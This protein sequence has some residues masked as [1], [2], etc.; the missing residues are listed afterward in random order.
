MGLP[1]CV[2]NA[3]SVG[4]TY[5]A[6]LGGVSYGPP[7]PCT[8]STTAVDKVTCFSDSNSTT[9]IFAP[10]AAIR[11]TGLGSG[12]VTYYGTSQASP[13]GAGCEP[14][15]QLRRGRHG[16]FPE[17]VARVEEPKNNPS[18]VK[19]PR[20][21]EPSTRVPEDGASSPGAAESHSEAD[22]RDASDEQSSE[23]SDRLD[24][25]AALPAGRRPRQRG[26]RRWRR[27]PAVRRLQRLQRHRLSR[28]AADL[29][30]HQ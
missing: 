15:Q 24:D 18:P 30:R 4:A 13:H 25:N 21:R 9:D 1:A 10:G 8:D 5:D 3:I 20:R 6:N 28:R 14:V 19:M 7:N 29:R 11:S 17:P 22:E 23:I 2:A 27:K 16:V 12:T 26:R